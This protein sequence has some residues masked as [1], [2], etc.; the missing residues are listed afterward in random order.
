MEVHAFDCCSQFLKCSDN[1]EC[2]HKEDGLGEGCSYR[3]KLEDGIVFY[4]KNKN[5]FEPLKFGRLPEGFIPRK[6]V[7]ETD[8]VSRQK[9]KVYLICYQMPFAVFRRSKGLSYKLNSEQFTELIAEFV[10]KEIPYRTKLDLLEDLP[11]DEVEVDGPCNSRVVFKF[12]D[13]E[14]HILNFNSY[15]IQNWFA[16]KIC[17]SLISKGF[18]SRV[19]L[20]G[21]YSGIKSEVKT[22]TKSISNIAATLKNQVKNIDTGPVQLSLF[23]LC[24]VTVPMQRRR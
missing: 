24:E 9:P 1:L 2:V 18:E 16:E 19:E 11:G 23:D 22:I 3:R 8:N 13:N 14:Y 10:Q 5:I 4:G 12:N 7:V 20:I 6:K 21:T 17:K 15:L